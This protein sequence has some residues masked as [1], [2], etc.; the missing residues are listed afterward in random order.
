MPVLRVLE[1]KSLIVWPQMAKSDNTDTHHANVVRVII[2]TKKFSSYNR[3]RIYEYSYLYPLAMIHD[4]KD[5]E[6]PKSNPK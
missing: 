5:V 3:N 4:D 1:T 2:K 6:N